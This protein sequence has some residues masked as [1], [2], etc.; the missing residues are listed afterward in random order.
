[1][2]HDLGRHFQ[3]G[4]PAF[5]AMLLDHCCATA[6]LPMSARIVLLSC[7]IELLG[8]VKYHSCYPVLSY[9]SHVL[10][11]KGI[12]RFPPLLSKLD[13]GMKIASKPQ[14]A[15]RLTNLASIHLVLTILQRTMTY[16]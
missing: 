5:N 14:L 1:M 8:P 16:T 15:P 13:K 2:L 4:T 7:L 11:P 6:D 10:L 12:D 9:I 3:L